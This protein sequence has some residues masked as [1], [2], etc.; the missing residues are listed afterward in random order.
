MLVCDLSQEI[1]KAE[2]R[3]SI[4][5]YLSTFNLESDVLKKY[6]SQLSGGMRQRV[7]II[8]SLMFNPDLILLDEPFSALDFFTKLKLEAEF[9]HLITQQEKSAI[10]VTHDIEEAVAMGDRVLIM[11][12]DGTLTKSFKIEKSDQSVTLEDF[13]GT[14]KFAEYYRLIWSELRAVIANE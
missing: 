1:S 4:S 9:C 11:N 6:P 3:T 7:S 5:Q 13:R 14:A 12:I 2:A 8:Q 10:L